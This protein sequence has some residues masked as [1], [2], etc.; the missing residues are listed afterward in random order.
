M[1]GILNV[2]ISTLDDAHTTLENIKAGMELILETKKSTNLFDELKSMILGSD[3]E[4]FIE[5]VNNI[6][7][8]ALNPD[9]KEYDALIPMDKINEA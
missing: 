3:Q 6:N 4:G 9:L 7:Q 2:V 5:L 8:R 1:I